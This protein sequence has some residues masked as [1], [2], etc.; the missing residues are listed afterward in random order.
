MGAT[1]WG[2]GNCIVWK[3]PDH[4]VGNCKFCNTAGLIAQD[5]TPEPGWSAPGRYNRRDTVSETR[6]AG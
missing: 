5:G 3:D 1:P 6:S 4:N 2:A